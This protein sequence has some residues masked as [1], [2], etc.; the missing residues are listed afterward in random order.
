MRLFDSTY[1][2]EVTAFLATDAPPAV[3]M[4][5]AVAQGLACLQHG[6]RA[7]AQTY[8]VRA[9]A[10]AHGADGL[11]IART[12]LELGDLLLSGG[13][14]EAAD[15]VLAWAESYD[16]TNS[17]DQ[18]L[19][20]AL[21]AQAKGLHAAARPL[22]RAS[23]AAPAALTPM[24]RVLLLN[25]LGVA[26]AH[27]EPQQAVSLCQ[28]AL[29]TM[30]ANNLDERARASI[31]NVLGYALL[32]AGRIEEGSAMCERASADASDSRH[33]RIERFALFNQQIANELL[34][35]RCLAIEGLRA[36]R[37]RCLAD[38]DTELAQ[39]CVIRL[40]WL[41][42]DEPS[43]VRQ[44][45][46]TGFGSRLSEPFRESVNTLQGLCAYRQRDYARAISLLEASHD[47]SLARGE[48]LTAFAIAL[49][50]AAAQE[51]SGQPRRAAITA[52]AACALGHNRGFRISPNWWSPELVG[53]ARRQARGYGNYVNGLLA[54][55][56][57]AAVDLPPVT[58]GA[59]DTLTVAG[60]TLPAENW[61]EGRTG[62]RVLRSFFDRL[63]E[64]G[65]AGAARDG[66]LDALWPE[67]DGDRAVANLYAATND[68]RRMLRRL[69]GV[70]LQV[71]RGCYSLQ[72]GPNVRRVS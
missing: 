28:L 52:N 71:H 40:A 10:L 35:R 30:H 21:I 69:P 16:P 9:Q 50:I 59:G 45:L 25:N 32:C 13:E 58:I 51:A 27:V 46:E 2:H 6:D 34:D 4:G 8:L 18:L 47:T 7:G 63:V 38:G 67:S 22:Y 49:W 68:L 5:Y 41:Q 15:A 23:L 3:S 1:R 53:V 43:C 19:L 70:T 57:V 66:L 24:T 39:W 31:E 33:P 36:L 44:W 37:V 64:S 29:A 26:L 61:R 72:Y 42:L 11:L 14:L 62:S 55:S 12:A 60:A 54:G 20:R 48:E 65:S 56:M 17:A